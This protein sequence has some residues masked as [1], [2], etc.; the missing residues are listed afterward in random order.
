M[1][2]TCLP[3]SS[4]HRRADWPNCGKCAA[5]FYLHGPP[6]HVPAAAQSKACGSTAANAAGPSAPSCVAE[7]VAKL[8][9]LKAAG[10]LTAAEFDAAKK[11]TLS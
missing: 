11:C 8:A 2:P 4:K 7:S 9:S 5:N 1:S 10:F 3:P 6:G